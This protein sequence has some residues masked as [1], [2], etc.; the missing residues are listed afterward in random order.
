MDKI[1]LQGIEAHGKHGVYPSEKVHGQNYRV[2]AHFFLDL[3]K[4]CTSDQ[5]EDTVDYTDLAKTI[6]DIIETQSY[7]LIETLA[8]QIILALFKCSPKIGTI[9][10]EL[11]KPRPPHPVLSW[12]GTQITLTRT[13]DELPL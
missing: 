8:L 7:S 10:I 2:T 1:T 13:R 5:L 12:E 11:T 9:T 3:K 6:T 4:A